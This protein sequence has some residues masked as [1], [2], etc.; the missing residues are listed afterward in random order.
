ML[1]AEGFPRGQD[2]AGGE[3]ALTERDRHNHEQRHHHEG[4]E[5]DQRGMGE[6]QPSAVGAAFHHQRPPFTAGAGRLRRNCC[7]ARIATT[8]NSRVATAE[9]N[10]NRAAESLNAIRK[11]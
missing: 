11:V 5:A 8:M 7:Q 10:P 1:E 9:A 2:A 4:D 3:V 6:D